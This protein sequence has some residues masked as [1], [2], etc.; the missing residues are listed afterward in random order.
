MALILGVVVSRFPS[1]TLAGFHAR[2]STGYLERSVLSV[3]RNLH[4]FLL[5]PYPPPAF[6]FHT[7]AGEVVVAK[8]EG[9]TCW[10]NS[11][12]IQEE[13]AMR[14]MLSAACAR[15]HIIRGLVSVR[16]AEAVGA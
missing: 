3:A 9:R 13:T 15:Q 6:S 10:P 2:G 16:A 8:V 14:T 11:A 4:E 1:G 12:L 5:F 7:A